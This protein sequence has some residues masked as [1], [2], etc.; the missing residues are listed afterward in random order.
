ME[1][2]FSVCWQ[3]SFKSLKFVIVNLTWLKQNK[4]RGKSEAVKER[5]EKY[6]IAKVPSKFG[7][8]AKVE[9]HDPPI[10]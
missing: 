3:F 2:H 7:A 6:R 9:T 1:S 10:L 8:A 5:Q 4:P